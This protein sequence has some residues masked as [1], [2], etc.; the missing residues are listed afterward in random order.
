VLRA[1]NRSHDCHRRLTCR[2][3]ASATPVRR[4]GDACCGATLTGVKNVSAT[5]GRAAAV[6]AEAARSRRGSRR[7]AAEEKHLRRNR[8]TASRNWA[9]KQKRRNAGRRHVARQRRAE[10]RSEQLAEEMT[11]G[12]R[13]KTSLQV[14]SMRPCA[15]I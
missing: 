9:A 13:R 11:R 5:R 12:G 15:A 1:G 14:L 8:A 2:L 10:E 3:K 4:S 6:A 7:A